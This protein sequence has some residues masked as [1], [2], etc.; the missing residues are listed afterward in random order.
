MH[1]CLLEDALEYL[2]ANQ[3][4]VIIDV[5]G[6]DKQVN[7]GPNLYIDRITITHTSL[8]LTKIYFLNL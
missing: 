8:R 5:K 7:V 4:R 3:V 1:L 6:K 2:L